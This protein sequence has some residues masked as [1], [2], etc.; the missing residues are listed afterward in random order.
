[1]IVVDELTLLSG[2]L[3]GTVAGEIEDSDWGLA[4]GEDT[5]HHHFPVS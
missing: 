3:L 5:V 4:L 1:M 2:E